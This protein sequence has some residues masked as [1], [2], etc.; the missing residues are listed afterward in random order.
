MDRGI[1]ARRQQIIDR[2]AGRARALV[3][4]RQRRECFVGPVSLAKKAPLF[5][6]RHKAEMADQLVGGEH[7][8]FLTRASPWVIYS[9]PLGIGSTL[10]PGLAQCRLFTS[11]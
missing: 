5:R 7:G 2:G 4:R 6:V 3:T 9:E 11:L 1:S 10:I 8:I